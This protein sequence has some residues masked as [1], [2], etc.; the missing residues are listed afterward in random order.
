LMSLSREACATQDDVKL[1]RNAHYRFTALLARNWRIG[2]VFIAGDAA[3][4]MPPYLGQGMTSGVRDAYNLA[5]K[6]DLVLKGGASEGFLDTYEQ[7][8][9]P[10]TREAI[11]ESIRVGRSVIERDQEKIRIRDA[12]MKAAQATSARQLVGYRPAGLGRGF[13]ARSTAS[14]PCG[15]GETFSQGR[16]VANGRYGKFDDVVGRGFMIIARNGSVT[17]AMGEKGRAFWAS[18]GGRI[19]TFGKAAHDGDV[20]FDDSHGHYGQLLDAF[21]C[22][23]MVKRPDFFLFGMCRSSNELPAVLDDLRGQLGGVSASQ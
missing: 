4:Q 13:I 3:H 16:V 10:L 20:H 2:R 7:E 9:K 12:V 22:D 15:A 14:T 23:I 19:A 1:I 17:A 8:R 21:D 18:L 11:E 6:L 5:W